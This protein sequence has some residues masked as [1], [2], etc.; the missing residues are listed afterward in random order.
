MTPEEILGVQTP[1]E[2]LGVSERDAAGQPKNETVTERFLERQEQNGNATNLFARYDASQWNL[3]KRVTNSF[4][5]RTAFGFFNAEDKSFFSEMSPVAPAENQNDGNNWPGSFGLPPPP[6]PQTLTAEQI[7]ANEAFQK[8]IEMRSSPPEQNSSDK[9]F[10]NAPV[11]PDALLTR[12][13][14][15]P[16]GASFTPISGNVGQPIAVKPLPKLIQKPDS[17]TPIAPEWTPQS[18]PWMSTAPQPGVI[19]QRKF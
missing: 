18:P 5:A 15:N 13:P 17:T 1:G 14:P 6:S 3:P 8:L 12:P 7:A 4:G 11:Q 10:F 9:K 16:L 2:I 19:P